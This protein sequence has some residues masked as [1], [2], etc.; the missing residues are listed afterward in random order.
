VVV[1]NNIN[2]FGSLFPRG[3]FEK[4]LPFIFHYNRGEDPE[5]EGIEDRIRTINNNSNIFCNGHWN[6]DHNPF[7]DEIEFPFFI[8]VVIKPNND[9]K[10]NHIYSYD[11]PFG[12][13]FDTAFHLEFHRINV[14]AFKF[15]K[16]DP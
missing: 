7:L 16:H 4:C 2:E 13:S 5:C 9:D 8:F 10:E 3:N 14:N 12:L 11:N 15:E 1:K 6:S